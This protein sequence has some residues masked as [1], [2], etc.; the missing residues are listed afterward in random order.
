MLK[1]YYD[2]TGDI[3]Y[4]WGKKVIDFFI[5]TYSYFSQKN[6]FTTYI[7]I[8]LTYVAIYNDIFNCNFGKNSN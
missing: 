8:L 1:S 4:A 3:L 5:L 6:D 7:F 2:E